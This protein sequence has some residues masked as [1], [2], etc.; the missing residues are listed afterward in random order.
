[1]ALDIE[2]TGL[3]KNDKIISAAVTGKTADDVAFFGP[4]ML[5]ELNDVVGTHFVYH[6]ASFDIRHLRWAGVGEAI[7]DNYSDTLI[8][9][10]LLDE[11]GSHS[12]GD[13]VKRYFNDDY[14]AEFW[15]KYK[16]AEDAPESELARYNAKDVHFTRKLYTL[17]SE[18]LAAGM[19]PVSL[20]RHVHLLQR[21]LL[22]TEIAGI[23]V[24]VPYLMQKGMELKTRIES[25][26][27]RMR[28]AVKDEV[29]VLEYEEWVKE[30]DKRKTVAGKS[31]VQKPDFS[32]DSAKQLANLLYKKLRLPEQKNEKTKSVSV[33]YDSLEKIKELHPVVAMI[34]DY[35]ELQKL[36]GT[37]VVGMLDRIVDGRVYPSLNVC[38][39]VTGRLSHS[40]PNLGNMP[41]DAG[42]RGMF[43][44]DPG[45]VF[46]TAD[47][48][49]LEVYVEAHFTQDPNLLKIVNDGVSKHDITLEGLKE[50]KI[51]RNTA[52]TINFASA[53]FCSHFKIAKILGVSEKEGKRVYDKYWEQYSGSL[54]LKKLTDEMV[55]KGEPII[56]PFGR[57]RRFAPGKRPEWSGDFRAAYNAR[58][59]GTGSDCMSWAFYTADAEF[60]SMSWGRGIMT[61]HDE[62]IMMVKKEFALEASKRLCQI[63]EEAGRVAGLTVTLKAEPCIM[64]D[65]WQD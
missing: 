45:Y 13:L 36:Y 59:Q 47:Y 15:G 41:R 25:L 17:L 8:L 29:E 58:I 55:V 50:F 52:K 43:I 18:E 7:S 61:L 42:L 32:F 49:A 5:H 35:R 22:A 11:N 46:V 62:A 1:M 27:P 14:K 53:Y 65:R 37:Y 19:V 2:T 60:R 39:T 57:R 38:G 12:L 20:C 3:T 9:A 6:N 54:T 24:D 48:A 10:H 23:A 33:D 56:N 26:L 4:E 64:E 63:M 51:D 28:E 16:R 34:Q 44:P 40:N 31:R 21:S 30:I